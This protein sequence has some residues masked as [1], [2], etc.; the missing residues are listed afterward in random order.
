MRI[1]DWSSD[2]CSSDLTALEARG[3]VGI[4][5]R[6]EVQGG[7]FAQ[8]LHQRVVGM[9]AEEAEQVGDRHRRGALVAVH[10]RPQQYARVAIAP[11]H[12]AQWATFRAAADFLHLE[13]RSEEHT[14]ELQSLMRISYAVFCLKKKTKHKKRTY[15]IITKNTTKQNTE[16]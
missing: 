15:T 11:R 5:D 16:N 8:A 4:H 14:S 1:S 13:A 2:V 9:F 10:L 6:Q 3:A 7:A 12:V